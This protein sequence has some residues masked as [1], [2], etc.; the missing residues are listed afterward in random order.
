MRNT[1]C[2]ITNIIIRL[3][4]NMVEKC[5][6]KRGKRGTNQ[7]AGFADLQNNS[8]YYFIIISTS[9]IPIV[10]QAVRVNRNGT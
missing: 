6:S 1:N 2:L 5:L 3:R 10:F 7:G 4:R 9:K 8:M